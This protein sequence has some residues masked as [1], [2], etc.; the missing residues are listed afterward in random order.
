MKNVPD[1]AEEVGRAFEEPGA[2]RLLV[3]VAPEAEQ[4]VATEDPS[5]V[6]KRRD[7]GLRPGFPGAACSGQTPRKQLVVSCC[8]F[9]GLKV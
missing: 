2:E 4:P 8:Q 9:C 1:G 5:Q 3:L 7:V 6:S